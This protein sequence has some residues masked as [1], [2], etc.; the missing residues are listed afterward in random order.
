MGKLGEAPLE[1]AIEAKIGF[2]IGHGDGLHTGHAV[3]YSNAG[4]DRRRPSA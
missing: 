1:P 3:L 2:V 4:V